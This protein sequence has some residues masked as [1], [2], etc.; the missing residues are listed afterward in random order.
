MSKTVKISK[1]QISSLIAEEVKK[2]KRVEVLKNRKNEILSQLN[3]MYETEELNE[4][5]IE[6]GF[7]DA[8]K[9][10]MQKLTNAFT[11]SYALN[12]QYLANSKNKNNV[13]KYQR[14]I[15]MLKKVGLNDAQAQEAAAMLLDMNQ[16][17]SFANGGITPV[18]NSANNTIKF[19]ATAGVVNPSA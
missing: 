14:P 5:G 9:S 1:S 18:F 10:G 19:S 3:E 12:G 15:A 11:K 2:I 4:L 16:M 6:E 17:S 13:L 8:I 7:G